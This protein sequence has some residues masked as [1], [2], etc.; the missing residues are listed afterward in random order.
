MG[1]K[2]AIQK[3]TKGDLIPTPGPLEEQ[4]EGASIAKARSGSR[5]KRKRKQEIAEEVRIMS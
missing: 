4:I 1:K 5:V 3:S 2:K